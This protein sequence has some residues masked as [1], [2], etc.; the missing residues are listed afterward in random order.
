MSP[1]AVFDS[2]SPTRTRMIQVARHALIDVLEKDLPDDT[3]IIK[4]TMPFT[5]KRD[6][7]EKARVCT[8]GDTMEQ[9]IHYY[10]SYSPTI[11]HTSMRCLISVAAALGL[12]ISGGDFTQAY[13]NA[14]Q[15]PFYYM[16]P[17]KNCRQYDEHG[18]R[19]V[20]KVVRSL[21]GAPD[22]GRN[23]YYYNRDWMLAA[24]GLH[25]VTGRPVHLHQEHRRPHSHRRRLRR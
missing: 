22:A 18:N 25:A 16:Y 9:G 5:R 2:R 19:I 17:P 7:T 15:D 3:K 13:P 4:A 21:Y 10:R 14:P 6:G 23:W 24:T 8:R 20:W 11:M 12:L 1:N